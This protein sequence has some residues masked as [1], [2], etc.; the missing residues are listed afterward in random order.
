MHIN[1]FVFNFMRQ[2]KNHDMYQRDIRLM[3]G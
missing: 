1:Y 3:L 2:L